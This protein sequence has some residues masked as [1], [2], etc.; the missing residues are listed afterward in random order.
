MDIANIIKFKYPT[1]QFVQVGDNYEGLQWLDNTV[2]KP[3]LNDVI[4]FDIEYQAYKQSIAYKKLREREYPS[5]QDITVALIEKEEGKPE[6]LE[7]LKTLRASIKIKYPK[8]TG[9]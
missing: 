8:P 2:A 7:A 9:K 5:I 3:S 1:S 4:Q 6:A